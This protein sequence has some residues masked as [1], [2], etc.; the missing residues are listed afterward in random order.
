M[1][2]DLSTFAVRRWQ[3]TLVAFGLLVML[4]FNAFASIPRS[5]DPHFP[6]PIVIVR[7]VGG[8]LLG[9]A[10]G[11]HIADGLQIAEGAAGLDVETPLSGC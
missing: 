9:P 2:F 4:G 3:F 10:D 8:L 1:K 11:G 5:E 6:I 7:A